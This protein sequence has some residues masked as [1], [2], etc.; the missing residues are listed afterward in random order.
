MLTRTQ[1]EQWL[2]YQLAPSGAYRHGH[3]RMAEERHTGN[4]LHDFALCGAC[5]S[6]VPLS[7]GY[8]LGEITIQVVV[9][10][11]DG[12]L[13]SSMPNK[14]TR[15]PSTS[16]A[17]SSR[18]DCRTSRQAAHHRGNAVGGHSSVAGG[19]GNPTLHAG[20]YR[21]ILW[22]V[23]SVRHTRMPEPRFGHS[24]PRADG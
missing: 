5:F 15:A 17:T 11:P 21:T 7:G 20:A 10:R 16:T 18:E 3:G 13:V 4:R 1:D 22:K 24:L 12:M 6:W 9:E 14:V 19:E 23:W 8:V 2:R